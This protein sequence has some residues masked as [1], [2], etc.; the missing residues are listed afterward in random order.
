MLGFL[1][2]NRFVGAEPQT[3]VQILLQILNSLSNT[4]ILAPQWGGDQSK[5]VV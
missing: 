1:E 4:D 2:T 5:M 3:G